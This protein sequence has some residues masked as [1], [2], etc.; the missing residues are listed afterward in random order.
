[1]AKNSDKMNARER[2]RQRRQKKKQEQQKQWYFYGAIGVLIIAGLALFGIFNQPQ[3]ATA[4]DLEFVADQV[5][6][7]S[8]DAPIQII[9]FGDF[10]CP[11]CQRWHN[12][13]VKELIQDTYGDQVAFTF[14]HFPVITLDSPQ[15]ASASMCAAEQEAFWPYHDYIYEQGTGLSNAELI[16]YATAV[17]IDSVQFEGCLAS[18][19]Y[20]DYVEQDLSLARA[21]GARGTPTFL[22]NGQLIAN[23]NF[24]SMSNVIFSQLN[25]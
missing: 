6:D 11:A 9:E 3:P 15:A 21:E 4:V 7:G 23:P 1:M 24:E 12:A 14:R 20:L 10:G 19:K 2:E 5:I 13:G 18:G 25:G 22:I 17:G 16:S 8:P